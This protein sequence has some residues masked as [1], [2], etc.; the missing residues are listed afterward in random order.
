MNV[1]PVIAVKLTRVMTS[2]VANYKYDQYQSY[3]IVPAL[4]FFKVK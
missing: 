4:Y 1:P 2:Y 3:P